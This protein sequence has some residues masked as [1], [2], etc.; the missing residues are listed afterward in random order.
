M[1]GRMTRLLILALLKESPRHGYDIQRFIQGQ[2]MEQWANIL[3]GSIYFSIKQME[4]EGLVKA[5]AEERA[6]SRTRRVYAITESGKAAMRELLL[7][8]LRSPPHSLKSDFSVA[9][10]LASALPPG[11]RA[12]ALRDNLQNLEKAREYWRIGR[13]VKSGMDPHM[14]AIFDNDLELIDRDIRFL[15]SLIGAKDAAPQAPAKRPY[16]THLAV[17]TSGNRGG[18]PFEMTEIIPVGK[19]EESLWWRV[20]ESEQAER[21]FQE[22]RKARVQDPFSLSHGRDGL[23]TTIIGV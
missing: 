10:C 8:A 23:T 1:G 6:G 21:L 22:A 11:L 20:F 7:E 16:A 5:E 19:H 14:G 2:Q 9:L 12:Q 13:T 3:S 15:E 4:R 17:R 18:K